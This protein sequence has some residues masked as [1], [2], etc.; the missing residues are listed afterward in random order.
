MA[1]ADSTDLLMMFTSQDGP[2]LTDCQTQ[3]VPDNQLLRGFTSA[4]SGGCA[5]FFEIDDVD[6]G[7]D[8]KPTS[9]NS[10]PKSYGLDLGD[11]SI[12][13][14]IDRASPMLLKAALAPMPLVSAAIVKRRAS[15]STQTG[16]AY[17]RMDFTGV[18]IT[19]IAWSDGDVVKEKITF[20]YRKIEF[21]YRSQNPSGKLLNPVSGK[22]PL[23]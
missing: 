3:L 13:R 12:D 20:I 22:W 1:K 7:F 4:Q 21:Q 5:N 2:I 19:K 18:L 9:V 23:S 11:V 14:V 16:E 15:G 6:L 8:L 17:M 10:E